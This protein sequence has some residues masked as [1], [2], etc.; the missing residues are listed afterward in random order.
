MHALCVMLIPTNGMLAFSV[1]LIPA[2]SMLTL[3]V[4]LIP[5]NAI[6]FQTLSMN[7]TARL[8]F[9]IVFSQ[10][11]WAVGYFSHVTTKCERNSIVWISAQGKISAKRVTNQDVK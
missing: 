11:A 4:M 5:Y 2:N 10:V 7:N 6:Y 3:C 8:N 9:D 1:M